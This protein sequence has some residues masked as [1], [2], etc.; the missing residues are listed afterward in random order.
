MKCPVTY[1]NLISLKELLNKLLNHTA[2]GTLHLQ[3]L[4]H[5]LKQHLLCKYKNFSLSLHFK[6]LA[7]YLKFERHVSVSQIQHWL[8]G[9]LK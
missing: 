8:A 2:L 5:Y 6:A 3:Q 4:V 9:C 1:V 7:N